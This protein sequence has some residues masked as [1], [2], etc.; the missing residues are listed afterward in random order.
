MKKVQRNN[1]V[2]VLFL[3]HNFSRSDESVGFTGHRLSR[4]PVLYVFSLLQKE[5]V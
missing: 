1:E 5:G 3:S 2:M 4:C